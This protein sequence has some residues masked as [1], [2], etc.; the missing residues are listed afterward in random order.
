MTVAHAYPRSI[1]SIALP[2]GEFADQL[3]EIGDLAHHR[4]LD[5]LDADAADDAGEER[6]G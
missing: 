2:L 1:F 6:A 3:F 5:C 4:F